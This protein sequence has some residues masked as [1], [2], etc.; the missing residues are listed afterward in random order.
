MPKSP[1][2][3]IS[4]FVGILRFFL[5]LADIQCSD[6]R[7][8]TSSRCSHC[9][10]GIW[11]SEKFN[12]RLSQHIHN[13]LRFGG[14]V[15]HFTQIIEFQT[16]AARHHWWFAIVADVVFGTVHYVRQ[17]MMTLLW[18]H[19]FDVAH[20]DFFGGDDG[21]FGIGRCIATLT[22]GIVVQSMGAFVARVFP[23]FAREIASGYSFVNAICLV[24]GVCVAR[25]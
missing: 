9:V 6:H 7:R 24:F 11:W 15:A 18:A 4:V 19:N 8:I 17:E 1:K 21:T 25:L 16:A 2:I 10:I 3:S 5:V 22:S 23:L 20:F 14:H 13:A 12:W